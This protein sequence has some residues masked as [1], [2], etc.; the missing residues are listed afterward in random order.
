VS[1]KLYQFNGITLPLGMAE[2]DLST[3]E[4]ETSLVASVGGVF[5]AWGTGVRLPR[6]QTITQ[7]G[8]YWAELTYLIDHSGNHIK[9]H[10]NNRILVGTASNRLRGHIDALKR[11]IGQQASLTR[12]RMDDAATQWKT[13]RLLKVQHDQ[14]ATDLNYSNLRSTWE[15]TM[16]GWRSLTQC[17]VSAP[18]S[19][20]GIFLAHNAGDMPVYDGVLTITASST[21]TTLTIATDHGVDLR[22]TGS[23][24]AGAA[25]VLDCGAQTIL[26]A[27]ANAYTGLSIGTGHTVA[28][29]LP[30]DVGDN[31]ITITGDGAATVVLT[32]YDQFA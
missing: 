8:I 13:A 32:W 18:Y 17:S 22:W 10:A 9:D 3:G 25:L 11:L 1:Y 19:A 26:N 15:T 27:G 20:V 12:Y 2:D 16:A 14:V 28:G 6:K 30:L 29:W 23:L 24:A 21:I 5:N 7:R 31:I 4:V